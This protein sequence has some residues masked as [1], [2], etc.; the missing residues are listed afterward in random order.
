MSHKLAVIPDTRADKYVSMVVDY[1]DDTVY[2]L[3]VIL[4]EKLKNFIRPHIPG[5]VYSGHKFRQI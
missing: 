4:N 3:T 5:C 2:D 1:S